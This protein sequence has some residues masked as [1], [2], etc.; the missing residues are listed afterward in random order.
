M[1]EL[2]DST[3]RISALVAGARQYSQADHGPAEQVHLH[4]LLD[5]TL[6]MFSDRLADISVVKGYDPA[7]PA[8]VGYPQELNQVWTNLIDNAIDAMGGHGALTVTTVAESDHVLVT[9]QDSGVGIPDDIKHRIFDPFFTTKPFG[10]GTG[11]G[12][13]IAYRIIVQR[14]HGD[15][16]VTSRPGGTAFTARLPHGQPAPVTA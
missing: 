4:Q 11:L 12:L 8:I 13:D 5:A 6:L 9:V 2:E 16:T 7:L 15:L 14:H 1:R 10:Q 3:A